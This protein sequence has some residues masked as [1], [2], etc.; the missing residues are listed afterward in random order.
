MHLDQ[1]I[2][3]IYEQHRQIIKAKAEKGDV[4]GCLEGV[5]KLWM[6]M[7]RL[8]NCDL[9]RYFDEDVQ[10]WVAS[11]NPVRHEPLA[12]LRQKKIFRLAFIVI[13]LGDL[14]GASV[15]HR[16]MLK[17]FEWDGI[18]V[19]NYFLITNFFN[20]P[21]DESES[22]SY[23]KTHIGPEVIHCLPSGLT[24]EQRGKAIQQ[25]L[26]EHEIDFVLA[27]T[28]P[29]TLYALASR[30]VPIQATM[31]QDCYTFA[32]GPGSADI[33]FLVTLDQVFKYRFLKASPE[34]FVKVVML[35]LHSRAYVAEAEE[36]PRA[37]L[38]LPEGAVVS[39]SSNMWKSFF[40]DGD[41]LMEGIAALIRSHNNYHH[42][43]IG[44]PRCRDN[45]DH[46]LARNPDLRANVHFVGP[47]KNIYRI[48]KSLD[49]WVNSFPTTG[50]SDI[51]IAQIGKPSIELAVN[52][53]LDLHPAEFLCS[54]ECTAVSL[55]EFIELGNRL[56]E[57]PEYRNSLGEH[58]KARVLREF[59]KE[60]L[61]SERLYKTFVREYQRRLAK[62]PQEPLLGVDETIDY[63]K[64]IALYSAFGR[65]NWPKEK[66]I[67][68]LEE[69]VRLYPAR[70]FGW[71][72]L[73]EEALA[74]PD[75]A[76]FH[77]LASRA[78]VHVAQDQRVHVMLAIGH[79]A[80]GGAQSAL[81]HSLTA[82]G[83]ATYDPIP[84]R[85]AAR[86]LL[87]LGR[88]TE[89]ATTWARFNE[90]ATPEN[91]AELLEAEP[92]DRLPLYYNY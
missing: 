22:Y 81:D 71:I 51:E 68:W 30:V 43:F 84:I 52:R 90:A 32:L 66:R 76:Q 65:S 21:L 18:Q 20:R 58:L 75:P 45:L 77:D 9:Q 40:G 2:W 83:L 3:A 80:I 42:V 73:L 54:N 36:I 92:D 35:P 56:I 60:R 70:P 48:L 24:H 14:G 39:G 82:M 41:I 17:D 15:P 7:N 27:D 59:D 50:G 74:I 87:S 62:R 57:D 13:G 1:E 67:A 64:R 85:I 33:T 38:G 28:C 6:F 69:C 4:N 5:G 78:I 47:V 29:S 79:H 19:K 37:E 16:F 26:A 46:F 10:R 72:K 63:E 12:N 8:R 88:R 49:F 61:I 11:M 31:S 91:V 25:W 23:L 86:L 89:A 53:N 34:H 44:T 55:D